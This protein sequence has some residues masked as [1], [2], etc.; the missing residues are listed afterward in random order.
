MIRKNGSHNIDYDKNEQS[1]MIM[2]IGLYT[3]NYNDI[4]SQ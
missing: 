2:I 4:K 3:N 1:V